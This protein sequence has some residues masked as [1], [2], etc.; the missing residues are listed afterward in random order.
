MSGNVACVRHGSELIKTKWLAIEP[1]ARLTEKHWEAKIAPKHCS[2]SQ[3]QGAK[4]DEC[5]GAAN[6]VWSGDPQA[7]DRGLQS[8]TAQLGPFGSEEDAAAACRVLEAADIRC[9]F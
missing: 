9:T 1:S 2:G 3:H 6:I 5:N 7:I 4:G 8:Y